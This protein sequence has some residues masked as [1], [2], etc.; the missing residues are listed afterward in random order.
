VSDVV[1]PFECRAGR[2]GDR[3]HDELIDRP[4]KHP[5]EFQKK[6]QLFDAPRELR[7]VERAI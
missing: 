2:P 6:S 5:F 4:R 7:M 1:M 3:Q